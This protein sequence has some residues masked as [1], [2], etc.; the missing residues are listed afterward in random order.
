MRARPRQRC[1]GAATSRQVPGGSRRKTPTPPPRAPAGKATERAKADPAAPG[2][3]GSD[4]GKAS[5][6]KTAAET[7]PAAAPETTPVETGA[8]PSTSS[9]PATAPPSEKPETGTQDSKH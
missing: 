8:L 9:A 7:K 2:A 3:S 5:E 4:A 6:P 1:A